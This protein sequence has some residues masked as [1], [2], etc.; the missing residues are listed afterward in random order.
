MI[1]TLQRAGAHNARVF[2]S[3][4]RA[5]DTDNSDIDMLV[6]LDDTVGLV[7]LARLT[8]ELAELLGTQVDVVPASTLKLGVCDRV[9]AEA[10]AP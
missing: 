4:A 1:D 2:G 6:D 8:R 9:L 5:E 10:I 3:V 7:T